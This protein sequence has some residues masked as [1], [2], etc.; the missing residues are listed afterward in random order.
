MYLDSRDGR[1]LRVDTPT[2]GTA[3]DVVRR[4]QLPIHAGRIGGMATRVLTA[5]LGLA[6]AGLSLTGVLIWAR[7]RRARRAA[8]RRAVVAG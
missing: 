7:K 5:L 4:A 1:V 8:G 6:I 2:S 3:G